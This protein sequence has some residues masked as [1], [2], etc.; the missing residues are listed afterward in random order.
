[1]I[2]TAFILLSFTLILSSCTSL[3]ADET[4]PLT[5][6]QQ[7]HQFNLDQAQTTNI[8]ITRETPSKLNVVIKEDGYSDDSIKGETSSMTL[9]KSDGIW[10]V[11]NNEVTEIEC[12]NGKT[13]EGLCL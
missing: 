8:N 3:P 5:I 13:D 2:K 7:N 10:K 9:E 1:M 12:Y 4:T 6:I 11:T